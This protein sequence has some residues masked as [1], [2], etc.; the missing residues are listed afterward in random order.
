MIADS[1]RR[2]LWWVLWVI[3]WMITATAG[4]LFGHFIARQLW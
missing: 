1:P 3:F 2:I 4:A